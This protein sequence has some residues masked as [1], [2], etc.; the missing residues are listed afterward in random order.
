MSSS[1]MSFGCENAQNGPSGGF[2]IESSSTS[3]GDSAYNQTVESVQLDSGAHFPRFA[4]QG[5]RI[6]SAD[7]GYG[8]AV[9]ASGQGLDG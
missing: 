2:I 7:D 8:L 5:P 9:R 6:A 1:R 4:F 3:L